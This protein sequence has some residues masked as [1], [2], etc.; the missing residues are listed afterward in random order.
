MCVVFGPHLD[1]F[2]RFRRYRTL[3]ISFCP[4]ELPLKVILVGLG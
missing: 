4:A 3:R 1:P 2:L